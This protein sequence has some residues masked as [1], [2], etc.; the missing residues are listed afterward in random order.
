MVGIFCNVERL[1]IYFIFFQVFN[2]IPSISA[3]T[4]ISPQMY[5]WRFCVALHIGPRIIIAHLYKNYFSVL[6]NAAFD[7]G[8]WVKKLLVSSCYWF[9]VVE[10]T[11]LCGVTYISN[12]ENYR[13]SIS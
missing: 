4:G 11:S 8:C 3:I 10:L 13:K 2:V 1:Y 6:A 7:S 12:R 5:V 9:N